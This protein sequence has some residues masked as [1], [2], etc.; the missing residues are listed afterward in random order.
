MRGTWISRL[1]FTWN[2]A[3]SPLKTLMPPLVFHVE[4]PKVQPHASFQRAQHHR[5]IAPATR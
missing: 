1:C 5:P 2:T 4:H 3:Q